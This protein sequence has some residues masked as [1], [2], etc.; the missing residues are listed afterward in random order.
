MVKEGS[1]RP[2]WG[3]PTGATRIAIHGLEKGRKTQA[4]PEMVRNAARC[5]PS[6][7]PQT[8]VE[9]VTVSA[10][11]PRAFLPRKSGAEPFRKLWEDTGR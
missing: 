5:T 11:R 7:E 3:E 10:P 1:T 8:P 2:R 6:G 4:Q 9:P